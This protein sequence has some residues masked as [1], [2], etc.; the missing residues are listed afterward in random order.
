MKIYLDNAATTRVAPEVLKAMEPYFTDKYGNASSL[1]DLGIE[2]AEA[3]EEG[4]KTLAKAIN[5]KPGEIIFTSGGSESDNQ[6]IKEVAFSRGPGHHIIT[7]AIEHP[8]VLETCK[9]LEGM[10]FGVTYLP[11]DRK[12]FISL[13]DLEKSIKEKTILVSIMHANNEIGTIQPI[14]EIGRICRGRG[15]LFHTDA[16]QS[17]CKIPIDAREMSIDLLS[18]SSHKIHGPK[19]VGLLYV[20]EGVDMKPLIHGGGHE[21][22]RRSGTENIAGIAGF[23]RACELCKIPDRGVMKL[24]DKLIGGV[25]KNIKGCWLNG[26]RGDKRLPNNASFGFRYI[27]GE[28]LVLRLND[29]GI[30]ASTGSACSTRSLKP[31]HVL[32]A[33]GL[34]HMEAHGS[35]RLTLSRYTTQRDI[36]YVLKVLPGV[37]DDLRKISPLGGGGK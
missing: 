7:S 6:A 15:V 29:R 25:L 13:L 11:V 27:E 16:V 22:G 2:A 5:A 35:L 14:G 18:A 19:G 36:D 10:G 21:S 37:V 1:H 34:S 31:S 20:R 9:F 23:A 30:A 26:P 33:T 28:A 32:M 12:G 24:R 17:F 3:L 8:A 4:R